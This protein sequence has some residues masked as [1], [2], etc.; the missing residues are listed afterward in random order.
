M[1]TAAATEARIMAG[2]GP[3]GAY[4]AC[5]EYVRMVALEKPFYG[6][7]A[8]GHCHRTPGRW[9][10]DST[11]CALCAVWRRA[12]AEIETQPGEPK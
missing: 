7:D 1:D 11:E 5:A 8:P 4:T 12:V 10:T 3:G 2:P 6:P 9:D